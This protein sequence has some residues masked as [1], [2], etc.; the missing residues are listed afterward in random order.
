MF[1]MPAVR[2]V[3]SGRRGCRSATGP[4]DVLRL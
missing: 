1:W 2:T 3:Q 4:D